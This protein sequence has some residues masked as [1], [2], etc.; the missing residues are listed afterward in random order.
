[1][2]QYLSLSAYGGVTTREALAVYWAAGVRHVEL[3]IGPKPDVDAPQAIQDFRQQGMCY[4]AHH[5]LVWEATH[6]PFNLAER[7]DLQY[8]TRLIDWLSE[9]GVTAY[10][11]H[12]GSYPTRTEQKVAYVRFLDN[13][14]RLH[15]LCQARGI[16]LGVE[17]MYPLPPFSPYQYLLDSVQAV[18]QFQIDAPDIKLALDLAHLNI[19]HVNSVE[20]K[21]QLLETHPERI[22]EIHVS[23]NDGYRDIHSLIGTETWWVPAINRIPLNVPIVLESRMNHR[24]VQDIQHEYQRVAALI[25][26]ATHS[27]TKGK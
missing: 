17:T 15:A 1:M 13:V 20:E 14:K 9:L 23:D 25:F 22:L 5:A 24:P 12:A 19:W 16:A 7:F 21:L 18:A 26:D 10:S 8:F 4:R 6:R 27:T 2:K 3:A 11:I